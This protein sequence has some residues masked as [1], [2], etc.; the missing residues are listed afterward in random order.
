[1]RVHALGGSLV[2]M[3][4]GSVKGSPSRMGLTTVIDVLVVFM[5]TK[6]YDAAGPDK[7]L[8][9]RHRPLGLDPAPRCTLCWC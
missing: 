8:R 3:A 9:R 1:M 5:F 4:I 2:I 7:V 6:P